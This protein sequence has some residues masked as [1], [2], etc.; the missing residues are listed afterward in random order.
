MVFSRLAK[1]F[2]L[3]NFAYAHRGLWTVDGAAENSLNAFSAAASAGLG[4]EF[5]IRPSQDG[6]AMVFHDR[7]L[8]RLTHA[9]GRLEDFPAATLQTLTLSDGSTIPTLADLLAL[10]PKT[11]PLLCELKIDADTPNQTFLNHVIDQIIQHAGPTALMSFNV[12]TVSALPATLM[13][14][15]LIAPLSECGETEFL[16]TLE[17]SVPTH[18]EYLACHHT[19]ALHPAVQ[20]RRKDRPLITWTVKDAAR[21]AQL[22]SHVDSQIFEGFEAAEA[23]ALILGD[24]AS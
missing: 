11:L 19:D 5:D 3:S 13:R 8:D 7:T 18:C 23:R 21:C 22:T 16:K 17:L 4:I 9:S 15:Q 6:I 2:T 14:G 10:W 24:G 1:P 20:T 12:A